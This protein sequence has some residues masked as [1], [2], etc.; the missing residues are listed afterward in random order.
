MI[1]VAWNEFYR[2]AAAEG[3]IPTKPE[4]LRFAK[5]LDDRH[6]AKFVPPIR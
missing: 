3:R 1:R 6:G 4:I 2:V 5:I